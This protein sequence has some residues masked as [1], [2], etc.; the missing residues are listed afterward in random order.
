M[1]FLLAKLCRR[2]A[3]R[4]AAAGLVALWTAAAA[5]DFRPDSE[6]ATGEGPVPWTHERFQNDPRDFQFAV[7]TDR[8][9]GHR[10]GVF[11]SAIPKLNLL[12]PEFV[13]SVGDQIEG[14]TENVARLDAEWDEFEAIVARLRMPYFHV[15]GN[16]DITNRV[17][18]RKWIERFGKTY[19]HFVYKDVL[20]L[21]VDTEDPPDTSISPEQREYFRKALAE[22]PDVRWTLLFMHKPMWNYD[23]AKGWTEFEELLAG[24][25]Y[26]VF[27]GH[28]HNYLKYV[29]NDRKYIVL[30]TTGAGSGLRGDAYGEFDH[31]VWIT[32]SDEGP[33][34]ANLMLEGIRDE[35]IRTEADRE[36]L[37]PI[38]SGTAVRYDPV[39]VEGERFGRAETR[40]VLTNPAGIPMVVRGEFAAHHAAVVEPEA[41]AF[42]LP[43]GASRT[44]PIEFAVEPPILRSQVGPLELSLTLSY[45]RPDRPPL[46]VRRSEAI[47]VDRRHDCP[48]RPRPIRV[49]G[50]LS[51]WSALPEE[52]TAPRQVFGRANWTGPDDASL[53]F[54]AVWD[55]EYL[56][57]AVKV[58]DDR[59]VRRGNVRVWEQDAV[60]LF[61]DARPDPER[62]ASR[63]G[64]YD[65]HRDYL[66]LVV[67]PPGNA[68]QEMEVLERS[69]LPEGLLV[70]ARRIE[71]GYA[72]EAAVPAGYLDER[73]GGPWKAFRLNLGAYDW[74]SPRGPAS[75]IWWQP[76]WDHEANYPGSGTFV[77]GR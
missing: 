22:H 37:R 77:R 24:R 61:L 54:G 2:G 73:Q 51:D 20:F 35:D 65:R 8:T 14:Y 71:G 11:S 50:D 34:I 46:E 23:F 68:T 41:V 38:L 47:V 36:L 10:P 69:E 48:Q 29:R 32:M 21:C 5:A 26:T 15:V 12:S 76:R 33:R 9:G 17:M 40:L 7:V 60:A 13:M 27:A 64:W 75:S 57:L 28:T 66:L 74:D 3:R 16:H 25:K 56:Y 31:I 49:D 72:I 19:Y 58:T 30:A 62:S 70:A 6:L 63:A 18:Q 52:L 45:E 67:A 44:L 1:R 39:Y 42:E 4:L 53:R 43:A 55:D 59:V